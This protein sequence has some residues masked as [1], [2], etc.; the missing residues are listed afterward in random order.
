[1]KLILIILSIFCLMISSSNA[2]ENQIY[3]GIQGQAAFVD[4]A[5]DADNTATLLRSA[6]SCTVYYAYDESTISA[7]VF[8]GY[9]I[10]P[11]I[12]FEMGYFNTAAI[13][14]NFSGTASSTRWN[15]YQTAQASGL[16]GGILFNITES[17]YLK[18]GL[19]SSRIDALESARIAGFTYTGTA[20]ATGTGFLAG[21]GFKKDTPSKKGFWN[22]DLIYYD[23]VAG[24]S[25]AS[26]T[27]L[28]VGY[29]MYF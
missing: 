1:M 12:S 10:S 26:I 25:G 16:D 22:G 20:A 15:L 18:G 8:A 23:S 27:F 2:Q 14:V 28:S 4:T 21:V 6:C 5:S 7:R 11:K 9:K 17:V 19:H 29:G 3:A 24:V 13:E